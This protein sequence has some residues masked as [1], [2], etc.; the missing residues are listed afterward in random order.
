MAA[1]DDKSDEREF[2]LVFAGKPVGIDVRLE[3][4]GGVEG[5]VVQNS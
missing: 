4:V 1:G 5:F 2:W 3:V